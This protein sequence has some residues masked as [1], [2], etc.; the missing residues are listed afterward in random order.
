MPTLCRNAN[1]VLCPKL[2]KERSYWQISWTSIKPQSQAERSIFLIQ[3]I[4]QAC[5]SKKM[6][7]FAAFACA[8]SD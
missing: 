7:T 6:Q 2:R 8:D 3:S 5:I 4:S 1:K